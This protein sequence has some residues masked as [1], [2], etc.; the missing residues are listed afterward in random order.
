MTISVSVY[1]QTQTEQLTHTVHY[2]IH[3]TAI[4]LPSTNKKSQMV[5]FLIAGHTILLYSSEPPP[6]P[7][8]TILYRVCV[9]TT[10]IQFCA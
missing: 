10:R 1:G 5:P 4:E 6:P 2:F 8:S 7:K 9:Y 3:N